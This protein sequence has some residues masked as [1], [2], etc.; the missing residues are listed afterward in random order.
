MNRYW[1]LP[2]SA[3]LILAIVAVAQDP[4][5]SAEEEWLTRQWQ[6]NRG[7]IEAL[8]QN[9][10]A[11]AGEKDP[12]ERAKSCKDLADRFA[13][14]IQEAAEDHEAG[15]ALELSGHF[16]ALIK[17]GIAGNLRS[18]EKPNPFS[19]LDMEMRRVG[20]QVKELTEPME[21]KLKGMAPN[22]GGDL[23]RVLQTVRDARNEVE[24]AIEKQS[25]R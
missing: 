11:L 6:R 15:R 1:I 5:N 10:L 8:V 7:L 4:S 21:K 20:E 9:G 14:E 18:I 16:H 2:V 25:G 22:D 24:I 3:F 12:I 17:R 13:E 23:W 19:T